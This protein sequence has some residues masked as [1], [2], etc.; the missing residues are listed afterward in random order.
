MCGWMDGQSDGG[1]SQVLAT[2]LEVAVS[3]TSL[4]MD[5]RANSLLTLLTPSSSCYCCPS[6]SSAGVIMC[7]QR[8]LASTGLSASDVNYVNA[9][10]TSTQV[11]RAARAGRRRGGCVRAEDT[12]LLGG[13]GAGRRVAGVLLSLRR[14]V[15]GIS[16]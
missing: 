3:D 14:A 5:A 2:L 15:R 4:R 6:C 7:L 16:A 12:G 8:A 1:R 11:R 10:A 13:A 9:H